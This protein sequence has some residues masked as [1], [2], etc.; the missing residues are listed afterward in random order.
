MLI[1]LKDL[2]SKYSLNIS[3]I[4]HIG[5]HN[6]E[7]LSTYIECGIK[8]NDI[9]WLEGNPI[10]Y[11]KMVKLVPNVYNIIVYDTEEIKEFIITNNGQSSSL[12]ELDL[13]KNEYPYVF[14]VD[15][16]KI[17]TQRIDNFLKENKIDI[18]FN[19]LNLDIQ[20]VE[21]NALKSMETH[22]DKIKYIYTEINI[23]TLYKDC[24]LLDDIDNYLSKFNFKRVETHITRHGWGDAFYIKL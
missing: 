20:G 15:R 12:L 5:A 4:L 7:E 13:H 17:K 9:I 22:L 18:N 19:F 23:K 1:T 8:P 3:G 10:I 11:D 6:C 14:E 21:L 2:I 16:I 24:P